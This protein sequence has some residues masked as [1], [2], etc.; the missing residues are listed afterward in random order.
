MALAV[1]ATNPATAKA[2]A[3]QEE[4]SDLIDHLHFRTTENPAHMLK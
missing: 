2:V 1:V 3:F 4:G